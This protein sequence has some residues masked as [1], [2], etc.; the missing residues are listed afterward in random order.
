M[1]RY[2]RNA[3]R[4]V[5]NDNENGKRLGPH[6]LLCAHAL[7]DTLTLHDSTNKYVTRKENDHYGYHNVV[8]TKQEND[9]YVYHNATTVRQENDHYV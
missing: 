2:V 4:V 3:S 5:L 1:I 9:H 6:A 8:M 7:G